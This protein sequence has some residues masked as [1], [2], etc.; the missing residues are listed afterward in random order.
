MLN[1][2]RTKRISFLEENAGAAGVHLSKEELVELRKAV[3]E[4]HTAGERVPHT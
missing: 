3:D 4:H 1:R 2:S